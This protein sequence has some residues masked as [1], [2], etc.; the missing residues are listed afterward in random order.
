M[1]Y[2]S[3]KLKK[4]KRETKYRESVLDYPAETNVIKASFK[5]ER[6][7][8]VVRGRCVMMEASLE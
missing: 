5:S 8:K 6:E 1:N 4:K 2:T 3:I 7:L